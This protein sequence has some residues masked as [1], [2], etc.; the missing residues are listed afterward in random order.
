MAQVETNVNLNEKL[1]FPIEAKNTKHDEKA[2]ITIKYPSKSL[3]FKIDPFF[4]NFNLN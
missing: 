3:N 2:F 1:A 4:I